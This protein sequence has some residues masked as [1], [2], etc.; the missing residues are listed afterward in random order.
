MLIVYIHVLIALYIGN[1]LF[2][3]AQK[4]KVLPVFVCPYPMQEFSIEMDQNLQSRFMVVQLTCNEDRNKFH[5]IT[6][7]INTE[8]K[9][10]EKKD[11]FIPFSKKR[12]RKPV[13]QL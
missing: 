9:K 2:E 11:D 13:L 1:F 6:T 12:L 4:K 3:H 7:V 8:G 10:V 5:S